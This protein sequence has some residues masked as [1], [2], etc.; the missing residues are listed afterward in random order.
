MPCLVHGR[1]PVC[2]SPSSREIL[3][4]RESHIPKLQPQKF[5]GLRPAVD[6]PAGVQVFLPD[7][8]LARGGGLS[9]WGLGFAC[10][11]LFILQHMLAQR[12]EAAPIVHVH[13]SRPLTLLSRLLQRS[14]PYGLQGK[15]LWLFILW[16]FEPNG[17]TLP[18]SYP[19][20]R[21]RWPTTWWSV[22]SIFCKAGNVSILT[23][24]FTPTWCL[25][26]L[27]PSIITVEV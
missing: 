3:L 17:L 9:L 4:P 8:G 2:L 18:P 10:N 25:Y 27:N 19:V 6:R 22:T 7:P 16:T 15:Q 20:P 21:I 11:G 26:V 1:P 5:C 12:S 14:H 13:F 23:P 24:C